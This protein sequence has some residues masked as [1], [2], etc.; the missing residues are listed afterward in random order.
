[1]TIRFQTQ[2][3]DMAEFS[4]KSIAMSLAAVSVVIFVL[5]GFNVTSSATIILIIVMALV[6][7]AGFMSLI[8][9]K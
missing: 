5:S 1:M 9:I 3:L 4:I 2:Y 6:N 7:L 8:G